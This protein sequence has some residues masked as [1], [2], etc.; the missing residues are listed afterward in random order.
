MT[1]VILSVININY[2]L[3]LFIHMSDCLLFIIIII[4]LFLGTHPTENLII[5]R[6]IIFHND[7]FSHAHFR[8]RQRG[9]HMHQEQHVSIMCSIINPPQ[10]PISPHN[11]PS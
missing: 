7:N 9:N 11:F 3:S 1:V 5:D 2:C 10:L 4:I 6:L 8:F